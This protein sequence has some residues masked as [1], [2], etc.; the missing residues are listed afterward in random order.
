MKLAEQFAKAYNTGILDVWA[1]VFAENATAQVLNAP[2]LVEIG[3]D[4]IKETSCDHMLNAPER[5]LIA[6]VI[7]HN[8]SEVVAFLVAAD[9]SLLD[10]VVL[11]DGGALVD[12]AKYH[13]WWHSENWL[14]DFSSQHRLKR[15]E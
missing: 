13:V 10:C 12:T 7:D 15:A 14:Q 1:E 5:P 6:R 2:M 3:R 9:E 8:D 11:I 4:K